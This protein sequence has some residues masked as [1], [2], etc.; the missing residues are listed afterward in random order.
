MMYFAHFRDTMI[1]L[2]QGRFGLPSVDSLVERCWNDILRTSRAIFS[3]SLSRASVQLRPLRSSTWLPIRLQSCQPQCLLALSLS[4]SFFSCH[5]L[6]HY[7]DATHRCWFQLTCQGYRYCNTFDWQF[8]QPS[9]QYA[10]LSSASLC[11]D[12]FYALSLPSRLVFRMTFHVSSPLSAA[13]LFNLLSP[14]PHAFVAPPL[15]SAR[16]APSGKFCLAP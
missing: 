16:H 10:S 14:F 11:C 2:A 8:N 7:S 9:I 5:P 15:N 13:V 6:L 3:S 4:S 1:L 12:L